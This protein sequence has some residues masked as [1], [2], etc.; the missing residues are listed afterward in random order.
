[1]AKR[2]HATLARFEGA[3]TGV[4][5]V[6]TLVPD[7]LGLVWIQTRLVFFIAAAY[8]Y[9]PHD[10]MR[11]AELL[12]L[13]GLYDDSADGAQGAR[14]DR[15]DAGR[16]V[17]RLAAA[18]G[19]GARAAAREDARQ[20]RD[21]PH[22]RAPVPFFAIAFNAIANERDTRALADR[23]IKFYGDRDAGACV[24]RSAA[25][26]PAS[27]EPAQASRMLVSEPRR[28]G[29]GPG[30]RRPRPPAPRDARRRR[31]GRALL[32]DR[33]GTVIATMRDRASCFEPGARPC[34]SRAASRGPG[35]AVGS[36]SRSLAAAEDEYAL[37]DLLDGPHRAAGGMEAD[38]RELVA[39]VQDP[40]LRALLDAVFGPGAPTWAS[41]RDAPAAKRYHQA[42]RHGLLEHSL[43]VAQAV[44]AISATFPGI[45]RDVAVTGALLHDIG[46][47]E[48]YTADPLAIDM[49]DLGKLQG[50]IPLGYYRIRRLIEDLPGFPD[51]L[52]AAVL[53]IILSH[54]GSLEHG[55]PVVPCTREATLVHMIDNLGGRLGTFDRLEKAL[56]DGSRW[57]PFDRALGGGAWF[58]G[59]HA[60]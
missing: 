41:F 11:P 30:P 14:R 38:L 36:R 59:R 37:E 55:S 2:R 4:G 19:G 33:T 45:D 13:M 8:G 40:H 9:D 18:A 52:A 29:G 60:A 50:E 16:G 51:E 43:S 44:S 35:A 46:K 15:H 42:Y 28:S 39:T 17:H 6:I 24:S 57:S 48:A 3:A 58:A 56:P 20:A 54:H 5:G 21:P 53:H 47:L 49:T 12:V 10:P 31:A 25:T 22:R 23:A 7:L 27:A 34:G 32:G 26:P 1:M